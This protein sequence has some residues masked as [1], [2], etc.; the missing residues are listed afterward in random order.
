MISGWP[1][2]PAAQSKKALKWAFFTQSECLQGF[3]A[4]HAIFMPL[5]LFR[6]E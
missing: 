4:C 6:R 1:I 5:E 3:S 2:Y